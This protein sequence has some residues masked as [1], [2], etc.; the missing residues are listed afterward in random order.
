[1][2]ITRVTKFTERIFETVLR[3]VPQLS[4]ETELPSESY[5]KGLLGSANTHLFIAELDN[6]IVAMLTIGTYPTPTGMKV[7]IEDVVV[8][9]TRRGKGIGRDLTR[10]AID[11]AKSLGAKD[12]RLTSRPSRVEA[13][14]LYVKMGFVQ[15]ETNVY[16]YKV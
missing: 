15:Y 16:K 10:Y 14:Q 13:N 5:L 8:D 11:Y 3:L 12:I 9:E 1:M 6:D 7:W 4:P 2:K